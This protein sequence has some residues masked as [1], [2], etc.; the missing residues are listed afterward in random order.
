MPRPPL[1]AHQHDGDAGAGAAECRGDAL[2]LG[3]E[4]ALADDEDG[5]GPALLD[6]H[7]VAPDALFIDEA[8]IARSASPLPKRAHDAHDVDVGRDDRSPA[9]ARRPAAR[10]IVRRAS[11]CSM[12][13]AP[14]DSE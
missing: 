3:G 6:G 8:A 1:T 4:V 14:A 12:T 5:C 9:R 7:E 11:R 2:R 10:G 13:S